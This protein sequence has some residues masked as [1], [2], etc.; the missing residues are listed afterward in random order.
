[1]AAEASKGYPVE[2][3]PTVVIVDQNGVMRRRFVGYSMLGYEEF[4]ASVEE[5]VRKGG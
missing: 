1:M 5:L 2:G 4:K 3:T